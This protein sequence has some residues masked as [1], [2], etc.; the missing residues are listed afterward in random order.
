MAGTEIKA[1]KPA[2]FVN[3][4]K[5]REKLKLRKQFSSHAWT[6]NGPGIKQAY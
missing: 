2:F 1:V 6:G 5:G 4:G 3:I